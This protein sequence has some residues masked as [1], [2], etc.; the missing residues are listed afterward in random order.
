MRNLPVSKVAI[1]TDG[2][3]LVNDVR[4]D[5]VYL[6]LSRL[7]KF[8]DELGFA[9][10]FQDAIPSPDPERLKGQ[11]EIAVFYVTSPH[12]K[13][14]KPD[15]NG[16]IAYPVGHKLVT[17]GSMPFAQWR[18]HEAEWRHYAGLA[19]PLRP[20]FAGL[21]RQHMQHREGLEAI[22]D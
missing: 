17:V 18:E 10:Q 3:T 2:E 4:L 5:K 20:I 1:G 16:L 7:V 14:G 11:P 21:L 9:T 6:H 8:P 22:I 15:K 19:D 12:P 13:A